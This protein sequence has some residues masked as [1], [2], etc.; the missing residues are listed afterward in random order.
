MDHFKTL[1]GGKLEILGPNPD[2]I[3]LVKTVL[4][5]HDDLIAMNTTLVN[6]LMS[7]PLYLPTEG[8]T[9]KT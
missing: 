9:E 4:K 7:P 5:Q 1:E 3:E 8:P 2:V 6:A